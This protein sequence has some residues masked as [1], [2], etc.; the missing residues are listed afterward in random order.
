MA[1][2]SRYRNFVVLLYPENFPDGF[3]LDDFLA[4]LAVPMCLSPL[5][6]PEGKKPHYHLIISFDNVQPVSAVEAMFSDLHVPQVR[7]CIS[8]S[9]MWRYLQHMDNPTKQQFEG[10]QRRYF[11]GFVV[12]RDDSNVVSS[13]RSFV[14]WCNDHRVG[15]IRQL[16]MR[17]EVPEDVLKFAVSRTGLAKELLRTN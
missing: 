9:S 16:F 8:P 15:S 1:R 13:A 7:Q 11:G 2:E 5:H 17:G 4:E 6:T 12:P 14:T 10:D 3:V